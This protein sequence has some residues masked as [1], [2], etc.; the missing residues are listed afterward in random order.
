MRKGTRAGV[1]QRRLTRARLAMPSLNQ[2]NLPSHANIY[3]PA[4]VDS[5]NFPPVCLVY[6][7]P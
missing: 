5:R 7:P 1:R 3:G 2:F 6:S 4:R